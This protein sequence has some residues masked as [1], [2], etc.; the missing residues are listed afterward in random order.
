M[1]GKKENSEIH[2]M[3]IFVIFIF[4]YVKFQQGQSAQM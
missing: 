3:R 2:G 1:Q 4:L